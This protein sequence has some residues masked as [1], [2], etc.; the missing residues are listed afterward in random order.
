MVTTT[1]T[2]S[3]SIVRQIFNNGQPTRYG[4]SKNFDVMITN[5]PLGTLGLITSLSP[6]KLCF[7]K[8]W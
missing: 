6:L 4:V 1:G 5:S 7:R 2:Y 8:P 3:S